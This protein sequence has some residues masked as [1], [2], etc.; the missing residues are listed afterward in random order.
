M[1]S[2]P[3]KG[4]WLDDLDRWS[5]P[6]IANLMSMAFMV[7]IIPLPLAVVGLL[8]VMYRWMQ[9]YYSGLFTVF[10]GTIRRNWWKAYIV[11]VID[12]FI[13]GLVYVNFTIFQMM[14]MGDVLAFLSRSVTLFVAILLVLFNLYVWTLLAVWDVP[15]KTILK[16]SVQL[17][18]A[19]PIWT[20][21]MGGAVI[22]VLIASLILPLAVIIFAT[23]ATISYI[24]SRGTRFVIGKYVPAEQFTL[25]EFD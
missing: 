1:R 23:G 13:G 9:G 10:F 17:V 11:T 15:L 19:Q 18:F 24:M 16:V 4:H 5:T 14:G 2:Q 3:M 12:I 6:V 20:L 25:L 21:V 8:G 7:L 22:C